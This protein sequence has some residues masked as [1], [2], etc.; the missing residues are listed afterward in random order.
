MRLPKKRINARA[1]KSPKDH[2]CA[3]A[4]P[5]GMVLEEI[6]E[7]ISVRF[8]RASRMAAVVP[9]GRDAADEVSD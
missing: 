5:D 9:V 1:R 3:V 2:T 8:I 7:S 4:S 6:V